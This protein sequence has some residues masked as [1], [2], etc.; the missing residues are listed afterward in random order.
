VYLPAE[1]IEEGEQMQDQQPWQRPDWISAEPT[2]EAWVDRLREQHADALNEYE[3]AVDYVLTID[4]K[5]R[6]AEA[7]GPER[8][9]LLAG[10][11]LHECRHTFGTWGLHGGWNLKQV[12]VYM[13]H[14]NIKTTADVYV[15]LLDG[16]AKVAAEMLDDY[17]AVK[18][19][20][21]ATTVTSLSEARS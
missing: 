18:R 10:I 4:A 1:A 12:S 3:A 5:A 20:T 16:D 2:G 6:V 14:A 7:D 19:R 9:E 13:G 17:I 11:D 21:A 8:V 15:H